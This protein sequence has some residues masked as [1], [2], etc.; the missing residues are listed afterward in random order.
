MMEFFSVVPAAMSTAAM[1]ITAVTP[2]L[3]LPFLP[4]LAS[5]FPPPLLPLSVRNMALAG[6]N[7]TVIAGYPVHRPRY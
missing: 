2:P 4:S 7:A 5:V 3:V 6:I 1:L